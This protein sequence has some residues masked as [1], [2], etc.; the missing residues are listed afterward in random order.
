MYT[1]LDDNNA[2]DI[3][4]VKYVTNAKVVG[5]LR[6]NKRFASSG[7]DTTIAQ[8]MNGMLEIDGM[9]ICRTNLMASNLAVGTNSGANASRIICCVPSEIVIGHF[10]GYTII[11]DPYSRKNNGEIEIQVRQALDVVYLHPAAFSMIADAIV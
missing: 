3:G 1:E 11:V 4:K 2:T 5:Y 7:A 10:T 6:S 9:E 8:Y